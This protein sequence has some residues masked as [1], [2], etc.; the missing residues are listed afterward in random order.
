MQ[1]LNKNDYL[2]DI[3]IE[4]KNKL[5]SNTPNLKFL[6]IIIDNTLSWKNHV[7]MIAPKLGQTCYIVRTKLYLSRDACKMTFIMLF[8][9]N[10][11]IWAYFLV[12]FHT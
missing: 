2:N 8:S 11:V 7:D 5:I 6:G 4:N 3:N 10:Y 1:F 9:L 12:K